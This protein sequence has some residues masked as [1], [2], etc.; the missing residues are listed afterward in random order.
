MNSVAEYNKNTP[1]TCNRSGEFSPLTHCTPG[2][3]AA[4]NGH[5]ECLRVLVQIGKADLTILNSEEESIQD[6][7]EEEGISLFS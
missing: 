3:L 1:G 4:R 5:E 6:C 7:A 2:H